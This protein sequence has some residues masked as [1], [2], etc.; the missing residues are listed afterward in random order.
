MGPVLIKPV[1]DPIPCHF[2]ERIRNFDRFSH[3]RDKISYQPI[4]HPGYAAIWQHCGY[5]L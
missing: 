3:D 5:V 4:A 1:C 2:E